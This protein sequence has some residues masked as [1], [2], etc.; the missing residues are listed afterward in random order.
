MDWIFRFI[1]VALL[2]LLVEYLLY[3]RL[4][5]TGLVYQRTF[6]V[7]HAFEGETVQMRETIR[8]AKPLPL[9]LLTVESRMN[10]N[11]RLSSNPN[12]EVNDIGYHKSL[13]TLQPFSK[14]VR[15]HQVCCLRRGFYEV[16]SL[17]VCAYDLFGL[18]RVSENELAVRAGI[19]VYP[20]LYDPGL[21][22]LPSHSL[23]GDLVVRRWIAEDPFLLAGVREYESGDPMNAINW[24]AT[25]KTGNLK[26]N[27]YDHSA[28]TR[29]MLLLN[30]ES[31]EQQWGRD[32]DLAPVEHGISLC[33]TLAKKAIDHGMEA[34]FAANGHRI[35][36]PKEPIILDCASGDPQLYNLWEAM[37][38]LEA[39]RVQSFHTFLDGLAGTGLSGCDILVLT[40]YVDDAIDRQIRLLRMAGNSVDYMM[41]QAQEVAS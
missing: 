23:M 2:F 37:A 28:N 7:T 12:L 35:G 11:L 6:S 34:G 4:A 30:V 25:A 22:E 15:T 24:K 31:S 5:M 10:A 16:R 41:L 9:P 29:L 38:M 21:F 20:K 17:A 39:R 8:N 14:I 27:Q 3:K 26:V 13:F 1:A 36:G 18:A 19:V 32:G 33:A 40:T